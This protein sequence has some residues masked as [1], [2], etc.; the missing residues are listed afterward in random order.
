MKNV[1]PQR[2]IQFLRESYNK[3]DGVHFQSKLPSAVKKEMLSDWNDSNASIRRRGIKEKRVAWVMVECKLSVD[4]GHHCSDFTRWL[5]KPF[6]TF[7][8]FKASSISTQ[9]MGF[10]SLHTCKLALFSQNA[11]MQFSMIEL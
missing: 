1:P 10:Y 2:M 4:L 6:K 5:A 3:F 11:N 7:N 8:A 9:H